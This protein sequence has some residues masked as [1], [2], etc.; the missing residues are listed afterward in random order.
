[1]LP[2][3]PNNRTSRRAR[4][5]LTGAGLIIGMTTVLIV[6]ALTGSA[7]P[8]PAS[9]ATNVLW[10]P[11]IR[12]LNYSGRDVDLQQD[13][14][15]HSVSF[16]V[17]SSGYG[18]LVGR[19]DKNWLNQFVK[20]G[21]DTGELDQ[22]PR[23]AF[24]EFGTLYVVWGSRNPTNGQFNIG[25]NRILHGE[26]NITPRRN[27]TAEM[28]ALTGQPNAVLP[29]TSSPHI[30]YSLPQHKIYVSFTYDADPGEG[31]DRRAYFSESA[32]QGTTWSQ[33]IEL[34]RMTGYAPATPNIAVDKAGYPHF[35]YGVMTENDS[36]SWLYER[37]RGADGQWSAPRDIA[38]APRTRIFRP[39]FTVAPNGDIWG[40]WP[41]DPASGLAPYKELTVARWNSS[42]GVW[43]SW[44]KVGGETGVGDTALAV[45]DNGQVFVIWSNITGDPAGWKTDFTYSTDQGQSWQKPML[46]L[47]NAGWYMKRSF[48][49]NAVTSK[50]LIYFMITAETSDPNHATGDALFLQQ[51]PQDSRPSPDDPT[52][53][54]LITP[55]TAT[56]LPTVPPTATP[57]ITGQATG[58]PTASTTPSTPTQSPTATQA[59][60]PNSTPSQAQPQPPTATP[61]PTQ[62][63]A[64]ATP[65]AANTPTGFEVAPTSAPA[66]PGQGRG[67]NNN[68]PQPTA[69]SA[70]TVTPQP[71]TTIPADVLEATAQQ[72]AQM[73]AA[74]QPL[75]VPLPTIEPGQLNVISGIGPRVELPTTTPRPATATPKPTSSPTPR[76]QT[77]T[78]TENSAGTGTTASAATVTANSSYNNSD[79]KAPDEAEATSPG[80]STSEDNSTDPNE[81]NLTR[82]TKTPPQPGPIWLGVP[83]VLLLGK[84]LLNVLA[85]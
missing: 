5:A 16:A 49:M 41:S 78:N 46:V 13:P 83:A 73:S 1:M 6:T 22:Y 44:N 12:V 61:T 53:T 57:P 62:L 40:T 85:F 10:S 66:A 38:G 45:G 80:S 55:P 74:A 52:P 23:S 69:T 25:F 30:A 24:D 67:S 84:G 50:G 63:P 32:D 29:T 2:K 64:T 51:I 70:P 77:Q 28:F 3:I 68:A 81:Q 4:A 54:P 76:P 31:T 27:L 79:S 8:A 59:S 75:L 18:V 9:A 39:K 11:P 65:T 48:G 34:G 60:S 14:V 58:S 56:P 33:P 15:D 72:S 21:T 35:F 71:T 19:E 20:L 43:Q 42:T 36:R 47:F 26:T 17:D 7:Q 37:V 82:P